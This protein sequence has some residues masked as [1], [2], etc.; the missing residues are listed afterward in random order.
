MLHEVASRRTRYSK[1]PTT[2]NPKSS[3]SSIQGYFVSH[4]LLTLM[5]SSPYMSISFVPVSPSSCVRNSMPSIPTF[6]EDHLFGISR[7]IFAAE[8]LS[9]Q[10]ITNLS[11]DPAAEPCPK[12]SIALGSCLQTV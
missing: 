10:R 7:V 9:G 4:H 11:S 12:T 3:S 6:A 2:N 5:N 8:R 1:G